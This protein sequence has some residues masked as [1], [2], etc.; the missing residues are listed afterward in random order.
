MCPIVRVHAFILH[1]VVLVV[2]K[3]V[4]VHI[5]VALPSE[6]LMHAASTRSEKVPEDCSTVT[7][8]ARLAAIWHITLKLLPQLISMET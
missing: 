2:L 7:M 3:R 5:L 8:V 1:F 6:H 4:E